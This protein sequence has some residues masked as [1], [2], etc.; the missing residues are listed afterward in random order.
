M[1]DANATPY[2]TVNGLCLY[3]ISGPALE[4]MLPADVRIDIGN[5][6]YDYR[7]GTNVAASAYSPSGQPMSYY[8]TLSSTTH[9]EIPTVSP[10]FEISV[11]VTTADHQTLSFTEEAR[12]PLANSMTIPTSVY[13][14]QAYGFPLSAV[15]PADA[16]YR[17]DAAL[18]WSP[19]VIGMY[20]TSIYESGYV[21]PYTRVSEASE[22]FSEIYFAV[23]NTDSLEAGVT[24]A[25]TVHF[26]T[27]YFSDD[28]TNGCMITDAV[29]TVTIIPAETIDSSLAPEI[30]GITVTGAPA[31]CV[32]NGK[33]VHRKATL[34]MTPVVRYQYGD[35][36][37]YIH[38]EDGSNRYGASV[39]V[40]AE[41]VTPGESYVRPDTGETVTADDTSVRS[42]SMQVCGRKWGLLSNS[43]S[44]VY[45]VLYYLPPRVISLNVYRMAVSSI[46]TAYY[47]GGQYYKK[48]DFGAYGMAEFDVAFSSL[49]GSNNTSMTVQYG[50]HRISVKPDANGHGIVVF[51]ANTAV[52]VNVNVV[53]YDNYMP[54]G[55]S[56]SRRL[57]TGTILMDYLSGG[58][59]MAIG[60]S[61]TEANA[62]DIASG[63]KLLFYQAVVGGY[64][65]DEEKD[66]VA[67]MHAVDDE[68][69]YLENSIY[70]N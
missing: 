9:M 26:Y 17:S 8:V 11:T 35:Q 49:D 47:Y 54:Y 12:V 27:Y 18:I 62:L 22:P 63:W 51:P 50:T 23:A 30:T 13:T 19:Q 69:D 58:K 15:V 25:A 5:A 52:S 67:W 7:I 59:G 68:L 32:I 53:L 6:S 57:S 39:P 24:A 28:F 33:Y 66:L 2:L 70:A 3:S 40:A 43:Y 65:G 44:A 41:G 16:H 64:S 4:A 60:K 61:A 10:T 42:L 34:T 14:G 31:D 55:V 38:T 21:D 1:D 46:S 37:S 36:I 29:G 48:D 56:A 20:A 45:E